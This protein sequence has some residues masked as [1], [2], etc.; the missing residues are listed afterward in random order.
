V[1][2]RLVRKEV[3][4]QI[5]SLKGVIW[6]AL[7]ALMFSGLSYS[8]VSVKELSILAQVEIINTFLKVVIGFGLLMTLILAAASIAGEK[9]QGTLESLLLLPMTK[10]QMITAKWMGA[11]SVWLVISLI[12]LPYLLALGQGASMY[13][14]IVLFLFIFGTITVGS[15]AAV[16]LALS[17]LLQSSKN[18]V[19]ISVALFMVSALP[20]FLATTIKKSG[21]GYIIDIVSPL[22]GTMRLMKDLLLN[23]IP[24]W[25]AVINSISVLGF[26]VVAAVLLGYAVKK[27]S[28]LG[29]E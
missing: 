8:F 5:F 15:F 17:S 19:V 29:G 16:A 25:Q 10:T 4:E 26:A 6:I 24:V 9:E 2:M 18:A 7:A 28:L 23:K 21:F 27:L 12:A 14:M 20:A 22:S 13:G 3:R 11:M 1:W